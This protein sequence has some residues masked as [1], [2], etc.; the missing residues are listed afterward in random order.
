MCS[1]DLLRAESSGEP[2]DLVAHPPDD[3]RPGLP[4]A[5]ESITMKRIPSPVAE[6]TPNSLGVRGL[7][8]NVN[9]WVV[10]RIEGEPEFHVIS[11]KR[12]ELPPGRH[13]KRQ[14]WEA[15]DDVGFRMVISPPVPT[16]SN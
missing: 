10:T 8:A 11:G 7:G 14:G 5:S 6:S 1:S 16:K 4:N 3:G 15:F 9:E 13:I 2:D 12:G